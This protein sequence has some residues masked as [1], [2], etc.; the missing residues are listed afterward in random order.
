[1]D[2]TEVDKNDGP[3]KNSLFHD[4]TVISRNHTT[5]CRLWLLVISSIQFYNILANHDAAIAD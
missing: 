4:Q 2:I 5:D 1:M 3:I